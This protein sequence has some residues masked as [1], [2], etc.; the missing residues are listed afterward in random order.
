M[1]CICKFCSCIVRYIAIFP[2]LPDIHFA[3]A[4]YDFFTC[5]AAVKMFFKYPV[6]H[7]GY[8]A[9]EKMCFYAVI[10]VKIYRSC[11]KFRFHDSEGFFYFPSVMVYPGYFG[12][13]IVKICTYGIKTI[14]LCF[15]F[16]GIYI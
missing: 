16:N 10:A 9:C 6:N 15:F 13:V 8:E 12:R 2:N 3:Q 11:I 5:K 7:K 4:V 14:V 1:Q